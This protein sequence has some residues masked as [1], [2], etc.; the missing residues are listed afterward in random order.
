[1]IENIRKLLY[2][3]IEVKKVKIDS[4]K[5]A[6]TCGIK[7]A[8][9]YFVI[10]IVCTCLLTGFILR[11][12]SFAEHPSVQVI[13]GISFQMAYY[14]YVIVATI[15][16]II[17]VQYTKIKFLF[18]ST[19]IYFFTYVCIC[20][21]FLLSVLLFNV[22]IFGLISVHYLIEMG[23]FCLLAFPQGLFFGTVIAV[24]LNT[25]INKCKVK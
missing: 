1:M 13:N 12:E 24:I 25:I 21:I 9:I 4:W 14:F 17:L 16:P 6:F 2:N 22:N 10:F 19:V 23:D 3:L 11:G 5:K 7:F 18:L 15:I 20:V 8:L